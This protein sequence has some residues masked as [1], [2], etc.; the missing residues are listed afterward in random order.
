VARVLLACARH[1]LPVVPQGGNTGL[2]GG[3]VPDPLGPH[4]GN[5]FPQTP[6]AG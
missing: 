3:G 6:S 5:L 2:V 4:G 1:G